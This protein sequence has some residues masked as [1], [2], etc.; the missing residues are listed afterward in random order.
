M[1]EPVRL[2]DHFWEDLGP[3]LPLRCLKCKGESPVPRKQ[4]P[5]S[6]EERRKILE[7]VQP[8]GFWGGMMEIDKPFAIVRKKLDGIAHDLS[9]AMAEEKE[10]LCIEAAQRGIG[11]RVAISSYIFDDL[12]P[13]EFRYRFLAPGESFEVLQKWPPLTWTIYGPWP[14]G[15]ASSRLSI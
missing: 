11:Y 8:V 1:L 5:L 12:Q 2:C 9:L 14:K 7:A 4:L 6:N 10:R 15:A 13:V 3:D